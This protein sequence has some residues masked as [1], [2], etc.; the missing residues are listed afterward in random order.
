MKKLY[1]FSLTFLALLLLMSSCQKKEFIQINPDAKIEVRLSDNN[2]VLNENTADQ[3]VLQISWNEPDFGFKAAPS[4]TVLLDVEGGDFSQAVVFPVGAE[5]QKNFTG[6]ELNNKLLALGLHAGTAQN[7]IFKVRAKLGTDVIFESNILTLTV[8]PYATILDLSTSWGIVGS[9]TPGGWGSPDIPDLPF[10]Q[11]D[12]PDVI[13]AYVTLRDGEIKFRENNDWANNYGDNG[14]D[15]TLDADGANIPVTAGTYKITIDWS[16]NTYTIEPFSWGIVGDATPNGWNGPD[17]KLTYNPYND[18]WKA[19]VTL[20]NGAIKFRLNNDWA[21]KYGDTGADGT[22]E[23]DGDNINVTAGHYIIT[24]NP[25]NMTYSIDAADLWGLVGDATPNGWNGP[26]LK[27]LPDFGLHPGKFYLNG[28]TLINGVVK[29][30]QNDNWSVNYGDD[31]N[32]GTLE[33]DGANIPVSAGTY[34]IILD[35]YVNPPTIQILAW[36]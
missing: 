28:V 33:P 10:Y 8:T 16:T 35:F 19:A 29:I 12:N 34:N 22:L 13:V 25:K 3:N 36:Q 6:S 9:A 20:N 17:I 31:G 26:D 1:K 2:L 30:R 21:V 11:T 23:P 27:F 24:F 4:Y 15:G 14:L 7:I 5:L 18:D 32:D